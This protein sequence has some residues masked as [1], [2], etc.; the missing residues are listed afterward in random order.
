MGKSVLLGINIEERIVTNLANSIGCSVGCW[1]TKYLGLPLGSN[2]LSADFWE[3]VVVKVS[4]RL[5]G[6]KKVLSL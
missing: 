2:P 6:W 3:P 1:P 4:K 5:D